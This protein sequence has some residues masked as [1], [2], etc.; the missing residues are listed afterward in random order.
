M[1]GISLE[2]IKLDDFVAG[3]FWDGELYVDS[4]KQCYK[5]L[6]FVRAGVF[7]AVYA[8]FFTAKGKQAFAKAKDE[9][10]SSNVRG[11]GFQ[12]GGI[13]MVSRGG[14]EVLYKYV[15][16]NSLDEPPLDD[17]VKVLQSNSSTDGPDADTDGATV[18]SNRVKADI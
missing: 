11:D 12:L 14:K 1:I 16:T 17:V 7:N 10:T 5:D 9:K 8:A 3:G 15:E 13:L 6:S 2:E 18:V 4:K